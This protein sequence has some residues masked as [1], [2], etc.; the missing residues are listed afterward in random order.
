MKPADPPPIFRDWLSADP[1]PAYLLYGDGAGLAGLLAMSLERKL[2]GEG[3]PVETFRWTLE[4]LSRES[5][6]AAWRSPSFF[7]RLRIFTLPDLA[8]MKKA[9]RDEIKAYLEAPEPSAA[10]ILH[11]T[12]FRQ[13]RGFSTVPNLLSDAPRGEKAVEALA[14]HAVAAAAEGGAKLTRDSALFLARWVGA[15]FDALDAEIG[16]VLAFA[17]GRGEVTEE[18]I[19]AVCVSRGAVD[20]FRLAETLVRKDGKACLALFR[21]FAAAAE[22]DDYHK[23]NGAVAWF[24]RSRI[25]GRAGAGGVAPARA[26]EIFRVLSRIDREMKGESRLSPAQ[27]YEIRLLSLLT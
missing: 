23:L 11:G 15:S 14:R 17:A 27:V 1:A 8:E 22:P 4:D 20:P 10:L 21:R 6:T 26:A 24:L 13:A 25:Q 12:D 3:I 18:D 19:R 16:K 2:R 9:H 5:P 7:S